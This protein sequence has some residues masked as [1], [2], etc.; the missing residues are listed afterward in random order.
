MPNVKQS[1]NNNLEYF[2]ICGLGS[3]GQHCVA[4][5]TE[6]DVKII[7]IE[8][9]QPIAWEIESLQN[10]LDNLIIGDCRHNN[11]LHQAKVYNCR[12]A[13]IVTTDDRVNI[14]TAIAIRQLNPQTRLVVRSGNANLN[15]LLSQQLGNYIAFEPTELSTAAFTLA[16]L[17]TEILGFFELEGEIWQVYQRKITSQDPWR[18][19]SILSLENN[20]QK[21][22]ARISHKGSFQDGL[23]NWNAE[24]LIA[25]RDTIIYLKI[26]RDLDRSL[27]IRNSA[28]NAIKTKT[29]FKKLTA[30]GD[31]VSSIFKQ[32]NFRQ[33]IRRVALI[34]GII[35]ICLLI[36]G[37]VLFSWYYPKINA[38]SAFFTTAIL[39][40]GGYG[41]LFPELD[42]TSS[43]PWWIR[44][45]S[46]ILT[47]LG[48]VFVG[49]IYALLTET[50]LSSRFEFSK[51]PPPIPQQDHIAIVGMG[52]TGQKVKALLEKFNQQVVGIT[53]NPSFYQQ[54]A[55]EIPLVTGKLSTAL[56]KANLSQAKSMVI[57]TD[58]E[59]LNLETAL[60]A[61]AIAPQIN[62]V[63]KTSGFRISSHLGKLL[64]TAQIV[65]VYSVAAAAFAGAAFGE[66]IL[67]LFRLANSTILVTEYR[68]EMD[69]TLNGLLLADIAEGYGVVPIVYQQPNR[70]AVLLPLDELALK[71]GDRLVV[72]A[73]IEGLRRIE[74]GSLNLEAK[75]WQIRIEKTLTT[76]AIFEGANAIARITGCS[77]TLARETMNNLPQTLPIWL[78]QH[79]ADRLVKKLKKALVV[80]HSINLSSG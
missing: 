11:I 56:T 48:T 59:I 5:L 3:L 46:L 80:S 35:I 52:N 23:G 14:E 25:Q 16:A 61:K 78:Y 75:Q 31:R 74:Q 45:F 57:V 17:G 29:R 41:D 34:N 72:L 51:Q 26:A 18:D 1:E 9:K 43:I 73:T 67:S 58:D 32:L 49:V 39:L 47:V 44:L 60:M 22:L 37:T 19:R 7:A 65:G 36:I 4:A 63:L 50:L 33:Q 53:F 2:I 24:N 62:L 27:S 15:Q 68:I 42:N 77:L 55:S 70:T 13:L 66:N 64:P 12:A 21:I 79:Q 8:E 10:L 40:L 30:F 6:F 54:Y 71:A 76:D 20:Y 38:L 69:D 28:S